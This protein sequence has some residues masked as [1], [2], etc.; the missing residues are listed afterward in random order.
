MIIL[1]LFFLT[2]FTVPSIL[3][4]LAARTVCASDHT[5]SFNVVM[6]PDEIITALHQHAYV[7]N[8]I[9]IIEL[10]K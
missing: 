10:S 1:Q 2:V 6:A 9:C 7:F 8:C 3:W 5:A 4:V